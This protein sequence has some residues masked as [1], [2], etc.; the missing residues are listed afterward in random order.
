[1]D[2]RILAVMLAGFTAF[3]SIYAP[4]PLLPMLA[5]VFRTSAGEI[6]LSITFATFGMAIASPFAGALADRIGRQR[7]ILIAA[8]ALAVFSLLSAATS[9]LGLFLVTRF[10]IGVATPG[11][12][13]A[14]VAY[15]HEQWGAANQ[16]GRATSFY[17]IGT[18]FGGFSG[19]F[20]AGLLAGVV[21]T[22][23]VFFAVG[24]L[25]LGCAIGLWI[26]LPPETHADRVAKAKASEDELP[27]REAVAAHLR[28]PQLMATLA[29]GFCVLFTLTSTFTYINFHLAQEPFHLTSAQLGW[30]FFVYLFGALATRIAGRG[31]DRR[32]PRRTLTIGVAGGVAGVLLTL[33]PNLILVLIGLALCCSGVFTAQASTNSYLG[34]ATSHNRALAVGL[35]G[36]A[37]YAG[38]SAGAAV[39]GLVW[40]HYG[41]TGCVTLIVCVQLL[42][43][44]LALRLWPARTTGQGSGN[45][46]G[47]GAGL[48]PS[49]QTPE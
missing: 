17:I 31:L 39:P 38:G 40:P 26:W 7:L 42:S 6:S 4:Q 23:W 33:A 36:A 8:F 11:I 37:Y 46:T 44:V 16:T 35:Y 45:G 13:A 41:W 47:S 32:G 29:V 12:V 3:L 34:V 10:L 15:I 18:I 48:R 24:L 22:H 14:T 49:G 5:R 1:M 20:V 30:L 27:V 2:T 9:T 43:I 19:R 28:N 21:D 25:N